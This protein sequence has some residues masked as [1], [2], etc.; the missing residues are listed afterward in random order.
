MDI[1]IKSFEIACRFESS[2]FEGTVSTLPIC[3]LVYVDLLV[4]VSRSI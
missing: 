4:Y 2:T 1:L 3:L